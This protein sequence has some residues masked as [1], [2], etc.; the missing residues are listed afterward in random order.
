MRRFGLI[1]HPLT[2]SFSKKY[3]TTK[4]E[5]L[6]ISN[7]H[8]YDL[9]DLEDANDF[10]SLFQTVEGLEGLNVTI[11]HKLAVLPHLI[12]LDSSAEKVGA[13]NVIQKTQKGLKG[14]NSDFYGFKKSLLEFLNGSKVDKAMILGLG[15]AARAILAVFKDLG[16]QPTI[17]S[18]RSGEGKISYDDASKVL[19]QHQLIINCSPLGT[20]PNVDACPAIDY[21]QLNSNHFLFDLVYNPSETLFLRKGAQQGAKIK[22]GYDMLVNQAEKSWEIWNS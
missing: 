15:G 5:K 1:G 12:E 17:V 14:Y 21:S 16:I 6:A 22:N 19:K 2:H 11:P 8:E 13:V 9:Y 4:F 20:Y 18:R 3:F 10:P 7:S